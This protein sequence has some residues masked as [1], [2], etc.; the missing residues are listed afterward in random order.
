[1][2]ELRSH[3]LQPHEYGRALTSMIFHDPRMRK[4][5][6][7]AIHYAQACDV[8]LH[9]RLRL[10]DE[11]PALHGIRW[12]LLLDPIR[13]IPLSRLGTVTMSFTPDQVERMPRIVEQ[14][15]LR[16]VVVH[17]NPTDL[18]SFQLAP[19]IPLMGFHCATA[20]SPLPT[21][22]LN[23]ESGRSAGL[24]S[25]IT[26]LW[27]GV[28]LLVLLAH[29]TRVDDSTY[30]WLTNDDGTHQP[31]LAETFV[32]AI[33]G[34][35]R[36]PAMV[37]LASCWSGGEG[38]FEGDHRSLGA[39]LARAGV[40][41]VVAQIGAAPMDAVSSMLPRFLAGVMRE[42][43]ALTAMSEMRAAAAAGGINHAMRLW[44]SARSGQVWQPSRRRGTDLLP[45]TM[46]EWRA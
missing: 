27:R 4:A 16:G 38:D 25:I 22:L 9:L 46:R 6:S 15:Q 39:M 43:N 12:E 44:C 19:L 33:S 29:A 18:K 2:A 20:L 36:P 35:P 24:D 7:H 28:G 37:V 13:H 26:A 45:E 32:E 42:N 34:L 3:A 40:G 14:S 5:W 1:M 41:S 17:S 10:D 21:V 30:V 23:G 8:P 11:S 31:V